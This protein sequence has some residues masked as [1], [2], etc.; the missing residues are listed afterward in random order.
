MTWLL[1][2]RFVTFVTAILFSIVVILLSVALIAQTEPDFDYWD[3]PTLALPLAT[4]SLT[5]M[6]VPMFIINKFWK[7][8]IFSY[9]VVEI[10]WL[11]IIWILWLVSG[12]YAA[13]MDVQVISE[14]PEESTCHFV[15]D[16]FSGTSL[17]CGE[18]KAVMALSF[19]LGILFATYTS[20]LL[21]LSI[22]AHSRG[23][24]VWTTGVHD[25]T[26]FY[27]AE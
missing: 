21:W 7:G 9:I 16:Y 15:T 22:R 24:S 2:A 6:I 4:G 17:E 19:F 11:K 23:H 1:S 5:V 14:V 8:T 13:W 27:P 26:L 18:I 12:S 10:V 25:G 20:T 3:V